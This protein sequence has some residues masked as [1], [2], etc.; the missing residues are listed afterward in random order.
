MGKI[1]IFQHV[2]YEILGT[3]NP[4]LKQTGFR[5]RYVNFERTPDFTPSLTGYEGLVIL[6][7]P[8]NVDQA[9]RYPHLTAE[10]HCIR[11]AI[12]KDI[13]V[14]GICLGAQLLAQALGAQVGPNP[15]WEIGWYDVVPTTAGRADPLLGHFGAQE[16]IFM[17][18]GSTFEIP[19]GAIQ[20]ASSKY[21][22]NQAFRFGDKVYGFQFHLEV[23]EAMVQR[24]LAAPKRNKELLA[25]HGNDGHKAIAQE[26]KQYIES[27]KSLSRKTF[28][29]FTQL[30]DFKKKLR[31][32]GSH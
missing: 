24:W 19:E 21:C 29:E 14:L 28:Q 10:L 20:L 23:D 18:H 32:L 17:W 4:L 22:S 9:D 1:L 25:L 12:A 11:E 15:Q 31:R 7:G 8:M 2:A 16:K 27:L 5:I 26:T 13:P 6:G 3:L 30:F